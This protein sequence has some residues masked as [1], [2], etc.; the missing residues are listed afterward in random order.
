MKKLLYLFLLLTLLLPIKI[1]ALTE[2]EARKVLTDYSYYVYNNHSDK[3]TYTSPSNVNQQQIFNG[4]YTN[5][6]TYAMDC[7]AFMGFLLYNGF[8][9]NATE[10]GSIP[11][12]SKGN[13][14]LTSSGRPALN[15]VDG[16]STH[17]SFYDSKSYDLRG[18]ETVQNAV[19]RIGLENLLKPGDMIGIVGYDSSSYPNQDT[20]KKNTHIMMY[21][22]DGK[23][24]HNK[25]SGISIDT[26]NNISF[27]NKVGSMFPDDRNN[28]GPHGSITVL[29]LQNY[30][31]LPTSLIGSYRFPNGNGGL[32]INNQP[33]SNPNGNN[34]NNNG[35]AISK[36]HWEEVTGLHFCENENTYRMILL[37]NAF[38]IIIRA[39]VPTLLTIS[40]I[41]T[42]YT[43][44]IKNDDLKEPIKKSIMKA[45][46]AIVAIL[47]TFLIPYTIS[48]ILN[49]SY[50][51]CIE[52][53]K[54]P[55]PSKV[56]VEEKIEND[57]NKES[58][59]GN[60]NELQ[61]KKQGP[62]I[63]LTS[64]NVTGYYFSNTKETLNINDSKWINSN[65]DTIDFVLLPGKY[66]VYA[67]TQNG[68]IH[69]QE[70]NVST[71]D[72]IITNN[73]PD[74]KLLTTDL[75]SF[76]SANGSSL[77]ELNDAIARSVYIA[78]PNT[79]E[80]AAAAAL[81]LTQILYIN[82]KIKIPYGTTHGG[83]IVMGAP[84]VWGS[85]DVSSDEKSHG[86][87]YQG[88]HCGGFISWAY[89]QAG[90]SMNSGIGSSAQIC[91]WGYGKLYSISSNAP[92][93]IGD[94]MTT[95]PSCDKSK[96]VA[97]LTAVDSGG[98]FVTEA[99]AIT[100]SDNGVVT[101]KEDI[102]IV[103]T[104]NSYGTRWSTYLDMAPT[105][106]TKRNNTSLNSGF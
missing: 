94:I 49:V 40:I 38:L 23:F 70:I 29:K 14:V 52:M 87:Y 68:N 95:A 58:V 35:Q 59:T 61:V 84:S 30:E 17:S 25:S 89:T 71:S 106:N 88:I 5:G 92:G 10:N 43:A 77:N 60:K 8:Q 24:I 65:K 4:Y 26:L 97:I 102:G 93:N 78:G 62:Y 33:Q 91:S 96:H 67:K 31:S 56:W 55:K 22:G 75:A 98:Y 54:D 28:P 81:S 13:G 51:R 105:I 74:I 37:L 44:L 69:E 83:H 82:Y 64:K 104:Y 32:S 46:A 39:V 42:I 73:A 90:F 11:Q 20:A 53:T 27:G 57:N 3:I 1:Y 15:G 16:W 9:I 103:T 19:S 101:L 47:I 12:P 66:Y 85:S 99:D 63:T 36:G 34:N 6:N 72:I 18:G 50:D 45:I 100:S 79:K 86:F 21:L 41:Y 80:G 48:K 76:L 7:N 2:D